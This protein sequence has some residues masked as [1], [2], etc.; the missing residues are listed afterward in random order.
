M[1]PLTDFSQPEKMSAYL[2]MIPETETSYKERGEGA[3]QALASGAVPNTFRGLPVYE[4]HALDV[5]FVSV[6]MFL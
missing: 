2:H 5:D 3:Y 4:S 6:C 1:L